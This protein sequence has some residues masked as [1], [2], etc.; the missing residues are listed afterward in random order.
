M[1][2]ELVRAITKNN[3][4]RAIAV[5]ATDMVQK[6]TENQK[7]SN[8]GKTILG[9]ALI[10]GLLLSNALL[11]DDDRLVLT[12]DGNGPAG[13]IVVETSAEGQVRGYVSNPEVTLPLND[14]GSENVGA[15]VG[16]AVIVGVGVAFVESQ[17]SENILMQR[18]ALFFSLLDHSS[19]EKSSHSPSEY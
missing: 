11:K 12:I 8:L 19:S 6:I 10:G 15:A 7:A 1:T 4:F 18:F 2:D 3:A 17:V 16:V 5:D 9:R 13:K 14:D